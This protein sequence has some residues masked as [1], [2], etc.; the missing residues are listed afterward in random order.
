M[1]FPRF[2]QIL[3][4]ALFLGGS[5]LG[6]EQQQEPTPFTAWI[7]L[8]QVVAGQ[9]PTSLPI[10]LAGVTASR[11]ANATGG[12]V[13]TF[14]ITLRQMPGLDQKR[15]FRVFFNDHAGESPTV[16]GLDPNGV[17]KF[18]RGPLGQGLELPNSETV[19]FA[20]DGIAT[21]DIIVPG[22]GRN[23]RGVFLATLQAHTMMR[24]LDFTP[25]GDLIDVFERGAALQVPENDLSLYGR[26][27]ATLENGTEKLT[28]SQPTITWEFEL[29]A[30]P[31]M[32]LL[33]LEALAADPQAP[34]EITLNN[35]PLGVVT[36]SWPDLADPGYVGVVR[37]LETGM[38]FRYAG[39][40]RGQ[41]VIPGSAL[42]TGVNR[43]VLQ[44]PSG[45]SPVAIRSLE[46]LLK[47][48]W[49][50]LDYTV[51]PTNSP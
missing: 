27:K 14:Q 17:Q 46:L 13:T 23:I 11:Q 1:P 12:L 36:M 7:D 48:N 37:P 51:N 4:V 30:L 28:A 25:P 15:L 10:W 49:K 42:Q 18:S 5:A 31:L 29:Q 20:T 44:L 33:N 32:A 19:V 38:H 45:S 41:K 34:L 2:A 40:L 26:V 39:W 24:A 3:F 16:V 47:H 21:I 6:Q 8:R 35:Q 9:V 50:N 43:L 22:D